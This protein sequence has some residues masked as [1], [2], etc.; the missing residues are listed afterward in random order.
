MIEKAYSVLSDG[1]L[2]L[3]KADIGYG[4]FGTSEEA[5]KK[6]FE[7]K[8]RPTSN[9]CIVLGNVKVLEE[10]CPTLPSTY[11]DFI[12]NLIPKTTLAV[13]YTADLKSALWSS[14][15]PWV[16]AHSSNAGTIAIFLNTGNTTERLCERAFQDRQLIVGSSSN[17]SGAGNNY[18]FEDIPEYIRSRVD[19]S[20]DEGVAK[21]ANDQKLATTIV[22]LTDLSIRRRGVNFDLIAD[23]LDRLKPAKSQGGAG[24]IG[25]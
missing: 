13:R 1:G 2:C 14:L 24:H 22:D 6:M 25:Q 18:R 8:G 3:L 21:Y 20:L 9:P 4:L 7:I 5:I 16:Q 23:A 15:P 17:R 10:L 11:R 12:L 19:F